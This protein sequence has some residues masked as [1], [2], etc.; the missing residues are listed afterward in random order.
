MLIYSDRFC[1]CFGNLHCKEIPFKPIKIENFFSCILLET[2]T[3]GCGM[4][5]LQLPDK[6]NKNWDISSEFGSLGLVQ[7]SNFSCAEPNAN[8]VKQIT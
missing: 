7:T 8:E 5:E 1:S 4:K 3:N 6:Y 2:I